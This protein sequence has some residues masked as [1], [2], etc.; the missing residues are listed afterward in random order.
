MQNLMKNRKKLILTLL[1]MITAIFICS[2]NALFYVTTDFRQDERLRY[3]VED[4]LSQGLAEQKNLKPGQK[5]VLVN[6]SETRNFE[7]NQEAVQEFYGKKGRLD[8]V[9]IRFFREDLNTAKGEIRVAL[10][11]QEG[12]LLAKDAVKVK[13]LKQSKVS[14][15]TSFHMGADLRDGEL[16]T[17]RIS[18]VGAKKCHIYLA[19]AQSGRE[20]DWMSGNLSLGGEAEEGLRVPITYQIT[21]FGIKSLIFL[22]VILVIGLL[23]VW[24]Q[25]AAAEK[26]GAWLNKKRAGK[27]EIDLDKVLAWTYFLF[28]PALGFFLIQRYADY[29]VGSFLKLLLSGR[30]IVNVGLIALFGFLAFILSNNGKVSAVV[31]L[32]LCNAAGLANYFV[33][34][35]RG[36]PILFADL[37]S[38]RTAA[39][40]A[41]G[42]EY[43]LSLSCVWAICVTAAA[44]CAICATR[45]AARVPGRARIGL[46]AAFVLSLAGTYHFF[47]VSDILEEHNVSVNSFNPSKNYNKN[48]ALLSFMLTWTYCIVDK[49]AGYSPDVVR[50]LEES[51]PSDAVS[52]DKDLPN[53][54]VVMNEAFAD[55]NADAPLQ[56]SEDYMPFTRSLSENTV[57][58][59]LYVSV[60]GGN[61]A[62]SEYEFLTGNSLLFYPFHTVPYN[63]YIKSPVP[64][65]ARILSAQGYSGNLAVHPYIRSGWNR[66]E[67][68][69]N[70]GFSEF[71]SE[72]AFEKPKYV[73]SFISDESN[74]EKIIEL[75]EENRKESE[76]PFYL[77]NV[78]VQN[79][80]SYNPVQ[81]K[82]DT[83][84][85]ITS[86]SQED[87]AA[88]Q[89]INLMKLSDD[90]FRT[91]VEYFE[92]AK[93]D[94]VI[95]WFGDHQPQIG[96]SFYES[97]FQKKLDDLPLEEDAKRYVTPYVI[98]ANYD[99]EEEEK[100]MSANYLSAYLLRVIGADMPGYQKY[101]L[102]LQEKLP[103]LSDI[104]YIGDDGKMYDA[105]SESEYS[106]LIRQY[107]AVQYN[108]AF[109][110]GNRVESFFS[111]KE[112]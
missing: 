2:Q 17:L 35:F 67:V 99:I 94:T 91:L 69:A 4:A 6:T 102:D 34:L 48:G 46:C 20:K 61:T 83:P 25:E 98:W 14:D 55:L 93:E 40:V 82:V 7:G 52:S 104:C 9:G 75:Y 56:T 45:E 84:I 41:T 22:F 19:S 39:N 107:Q 103:V 12:D 74:M 27:R 111:L 30:G 43:G 80:S 70:M 8:E 60:F 54:I 109:D 53:V 88:E 24:F 79:H 31:M 11:N 100:D 42:Y 49:P 106:D 28:T 89:Y 13:K 86:K 16:Y 36:T 78:T 68:Y 71:L 58:G 26:A 29:G 38:L 108:N 50:K 62:N 23:A 64:S 33:V 3:M 72:E 90:S 81:G 66:E 51:Y 59:N 96:T 18:A 97:L 85:K 105:D 47:F 92:N 101:L 57:R 73:R 44:C 95:V 32:L 65:L 110:D 15:S 37:L 77:F 1:L 21:Y 76:D 63:S 112:E 5:T 87:D 10:Y